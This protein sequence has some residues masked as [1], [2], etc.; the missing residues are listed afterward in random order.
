MA[1]RQFYTGITIISCRGEACKELAVE[2]DLCLTFN[3]QLHIFFHCLQA[4]FGLYSCC[5]LGH[6]GTCL[7]GLVSC[8]LVYILTCR[9]SLKAKCFRVSLIRDLFRLLQGIAIFPTLNAS[10]RMPSINIFFFEH[11]PKKHVCNEYSKCP[12][13]LWH[14]YIRKAIIKTLSYNMSTFPILHPLR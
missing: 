12:R 2:F 10:S 3:K 7:M 6:A 11:K 4:L 13:K 9:Y 1:K 5:T 8:R 14:K